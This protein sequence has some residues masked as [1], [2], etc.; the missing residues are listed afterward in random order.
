MPCQRTVRID[1]VAGLTKSSN[2]CQ[3]SPPDSS[4]HAPSFDVELPVAFNVSCTGAESWDAPEGGAVEDPDGVGTV[5]DW[6]HATH[7][8]TT[9]T[10]N[11]E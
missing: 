5:G 2:I 3:S 11:R 8:I 9:R 6:P 7:D 4:D 1:V 10:A